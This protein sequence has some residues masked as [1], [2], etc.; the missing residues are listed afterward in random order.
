MTTKPSIQFKSKK[1]DDAQVD[2]P[3]TAA[4]AVDQPE[5][6]DPEAP[7]PTAPVV[8]KLDDVPYV[9]PDEA[10]KDIL[11][12]AQAVAS[13]MQGSRPAATIQSRKTA[14]TPPGYYSHQLTYVRP[15]GGKPVLGKAINGRA[16]WPFSSPEAVLEVLRAGVESGIVTVLGQPPKE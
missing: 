14:P 12:S 13:G 6:P 5:A 10:L 15:S 1:Q 3:Q 16:Y 9:S 4:P 7:E 11:K 8:P 2:L